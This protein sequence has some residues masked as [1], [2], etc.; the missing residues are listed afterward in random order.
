MTKMEELMKEQQKQSAAKLEEVKEE[1]KK[2]TN[3]VAKANTDPKV[4]AN[5]GAAAGG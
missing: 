4:A 5:G 2:Q 3:E 1:T